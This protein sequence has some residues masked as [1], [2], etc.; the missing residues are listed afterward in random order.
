MIRI[1]NTVKW[2]KA[3]ILWWDLWIKI[4]IAISILF[5]K[6]QLNIAIVLVFLHSH[7]AFQIWNINISFILITTIF[8]I[9]IQPLFPFSLNLANTWWRHQMETFSTLLAICAGNL[10]VK[11]NSPH[12]GQGRRAL[13][14]FFICIWINGWVNNR[15]AGDFRHYGAHY[16]ITLIMLWEVLRRKSFSKS[17]PCPRQRG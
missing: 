1:H 8:D 4:H 3:N 12:K 16:D 5:I 6:C 7:I 10:L 15:E 17:S 13:M 11:V 9:W 14:F 2:L